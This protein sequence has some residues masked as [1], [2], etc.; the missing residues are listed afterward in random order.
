[1]YL[2][3]TINLVL[4]LRRR[5]VD[6][7][8][9]VADIVNG[10]VGRRVNFDE[11]EEAI[12]VDGFAIF[13]F[14][15]G[16]FCR[17]GIRAIDR[18]RQQTRERGLPRSARTREEI[19]VRDAVCRDGILQRGDDVVLSQHGAPFLGSVFSVEGLGHFSKSVISE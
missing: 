15:V 16:T 5:E 3:N 17:V 14:V 7:V 2:I 11:V 6:L 18:L 13:T 10:C 8:A 19:R 1:M 12:L 4:A 9:Q